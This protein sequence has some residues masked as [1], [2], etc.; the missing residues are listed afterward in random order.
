MAVDEMLL[1]RAQGQ[2]AASLRIYR[3]K[4]PTLSLGY[5]Q[6][7]ADREQHSASRHC[8]AVRRL[9]GGGAIMHDKEITYS[10][11]LPGRHPLAARRDELYRALHGC[12]IEALADF[13]ATARLCEASGKGATDG[14]AFL[15]FQRRSPGDVV[16]GDYKICGS[17]QRRRN[18]AV[19]QHGSL[20]WRASQAAPELPGVA[21]LAARPIS[22]DIML[23][24][25]LD[26][27]ARRLQFAWRRDNL[28]ET[29]AREAVAIAGSRYGSDDWTK[30]RGRR[31]EAGRS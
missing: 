31:V 2:A 10:I 15:C 18:G 4:E 19:L 7:Y 20:L 23:K 24:T 11:V 30:Y 3:W 22:Q 12:L 13:G 26:S 21:D 16:L 27:L 25:W 29:E 17:A 6:R 5:F 28:V 1:N 9:T 8:T 14:K